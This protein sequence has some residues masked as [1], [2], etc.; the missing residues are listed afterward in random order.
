MACRAQ[1]R[2]ADLRPLRQRSPPVPPRT[3]RRTWSLACATST[4]GIPTPGT[5][6]WT[7]RDANNVELRLPAAT[8]ARRQPGVRGEDHRSRPRSRSRSSPRPSP[9]GRPSPIASTPTAAPARRRRSGIRSAAPRS[10]RPTDGAGSSSSRS[11]TA[12]GRSSAP[13]CTRRPTRSGKYPALTFTPGLQSYNEV[14]SWFAEGMAEAGYVVLIID[15][16]GQGDSENCGHTPDGT[17]TTCPTTDQPNDTRSAIDFIL[18]TPS[19]P[20]PWALGVNAAGTPTFNPFWQRIDRRAPRHRR[21]F[22]RRDRGHTDRP[23]RRSRR[24]RR[25]LRQPRPPAAGTRS[26]RRTPT[27]FFGTDYAFPATGTPKTSPP[28][29]DAA[30]RRLRSACRRQGRLDVDHHPRQRPLR[31]RLPARRRPTF[32]PAA[33]ANGSRSTTR[34]PGSTG[35]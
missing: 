6:A 10:G 31:V 13:A 7:A 5:A 2:T 9:S 19:S 12:T 17:Q 28:D 3:G 14:N 23:G 30:R 15:P 22:A 21:P 20:Y 26:P 18:S 8:D 24:R 11:S 33:T 32:P 34:W 27:L 16:Q 35:T 25:L 29:P 4:P 1:C